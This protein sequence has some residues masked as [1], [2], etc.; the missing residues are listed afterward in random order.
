MLLR[1][2][3]CLWGDEGCGKTVLAQALVDNLRG[4]GYLV[5]FSEPASPKQM[6]MAIAE[7]FG[8][9]TQT[10]EGKRLTLEALK[11]AISDFMFNHH[12]VLIIDD[13]HLCKVDFRHWLKKCRSRGGCHLVLFATHPPLSDIFL[14]MPRKRLA[15]LSGRAIR[16]IMAYE[17]KL[18]GIQLTNADFA[19][20]QASAGGNPALA[21]RS[22]EEEYLG[23]EQETA[24]HKQFVVI[25]SVLM[26]IGTL[27]VVLRFIGLGT[28][29]RNLYILGG[30]GGSVFIGVS[31]L[32]YS[33]PKEGR[34]IK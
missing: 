5:A 25:T 13:A 21:I 27:L 33:L 31:R 20:L 30:I 14:T 10:L 24:D 19:R 23:V 34:R 3:I 12:T 26:M 4:E 6:L 15:P 17:A 8:L 9:S 2:S 22:I 11:L 1:G 18:R 28:S 16:G 29:D 32:V 7:Q